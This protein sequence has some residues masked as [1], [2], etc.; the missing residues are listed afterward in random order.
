MTRLSLLAEEFQLQGWAT[1]TILALW[2]DPVRSM[3]YKLVPCWLTSLTTIKLGL[4]R[5]SATKWIMTWQSSQIQKS[6]S[7]QWTTIINSNLLKIFNMPKVLKTF[8]ML[9][10]SRII[11]QKT[12]NKRKRSKKL[13]LRTFPSRAYKILQKKALNPKKFLT[14]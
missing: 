13:L 2:E 9:K 1:V 14:V 7:R 11:N 5:P 4:K 12:K 8:Q 10:M 3:I 6:N